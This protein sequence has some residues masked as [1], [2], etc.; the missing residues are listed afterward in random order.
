MTDVVVIGGIFREV[1]DGDRDPKKRFG[2]SG[3]TA[4]IVC[5][6]LGVTTALVSYAGNEDIATVTAMLEAGGVDHGSVLTIPGASGT[7]VFP[8]ESPGPRR[9]PWPMYRP[10]EAVPATVPRIPPAKVYVAFGI[11]DFD[12]VAAGWLESLPV[13]TLL[14]WDRQG[15]LSRSRDSRAAASL[16]PRY[17]LYL[18]NRDE[19]MAEFPGTSEA[20][21][22]ASL[23]PPGYLA[24][25]VKRGHE[26]CI[27]VNGTT[28]ARV[29]KRVPAF[30][31]R[32]KSTIG[33]GDALAAGV[34]AELA[35]GTGLEMAVIAGNAIAA[36]LL[37]SNGDPL[38]EGLVERS[39]NLLSSVQSPRATN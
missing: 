11:P 8:S 16:R 28:G 1:L 12:P 5:A 24:A 3:L 13:D 25:I 37:E 30:S 2:G 39:R 14:M 19:V 27:L 31:V 32:A 35:N 15:W 18:A 21:T 36:A 22:L 26:G 23:P 6:R 17:K 20:A 34:A 38:S 33:S 29:E 4:A 10:A 7:F 9:P